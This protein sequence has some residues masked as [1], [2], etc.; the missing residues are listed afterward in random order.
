VYLSRGKSHSA[1]AVCKFFNTLSNFEILKIMNFK[2]LLF[3]ALLCAS[4]LS[5]SPTDAVEQSYT[6]EIEAAKATEILQAEDNT[7]ALRVKGLICET[8]AF[9]IN[10][11]LRKVDGIDRSR[12]DK[13]LQMDIYTQFLTLA[14]EPGEAIDLRAIVK[15]VSDAGYDPISIYLLEDG[16]LLG[17]QYTVPGI[18]TPLNLTVESTDLASEQLIS[19]RQSDLKAQSYI[20]EL[21][22]TL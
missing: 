14:R 13:G 21:T 2:T 17:E 1:N 12:F 18:D 15:A 8:C 19:I 11:K 16:E 22:S 7:V 9:G 10:R 6:P 20:A 5:A 3:T 4:A